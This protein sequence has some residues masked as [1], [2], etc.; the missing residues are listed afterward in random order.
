MRFGDFGRLHFSDERAQRCLIRSRGSLVDFISPDLKT[1]QPIRTK[2]HRDRHIGGIASAG[3]QNST[4]PGRIVS[5]IKCVPAAA[6]ISFEPSRKV[7]GRKRRPR[8][9]VPEVASAIARRDIQ[10]AAECDGQMRIIATDPAAL[11]IC[12]ARRPRHSRVLVSKADV[13]VHEI[14]D[15]LHAIPTWRGGSK[16]CPCEFE[17]SVAL[18]EAARQ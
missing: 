8:A 7:P 9:H 15:G 1:F 13:P 10:S 12:F 2:G 5:R 6:D 3:Y 17:K 11:F 18:A 16:Q 14:A 4:D